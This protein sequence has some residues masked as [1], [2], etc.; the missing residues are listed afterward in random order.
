MAAVAPA[1]TPAIFKE[2]RVPTSSP[3]EKGESTRP[4]R[5]R[6]VDIGQTNSAKPSNGFAKPVPSG[7][8]RTGGELDGG[9]DRQAAFARELE[10]LGVFDFSESGP[11][12]R[13][14]ENIMEELGYAVDGF[15]QE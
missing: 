10:A 7:R 4:G 13:E 1:Q 14:F 8:T 15:S 11:L 5:S 12:A 9:Y 3:P 2:N 6:R